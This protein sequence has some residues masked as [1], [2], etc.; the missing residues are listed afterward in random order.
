MFSDL[1]SERPCLYVLRD[2]HHHTIHVGPEQWLR[3]EIPAL[4]GEMLKA[5]EF[6]VILSHM[7]S[8]AT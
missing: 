2:V 7:V 1:G 8:W 4:V 6:K 3:P 5:Q